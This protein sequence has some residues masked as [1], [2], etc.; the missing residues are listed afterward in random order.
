[1]PGHPV[2]QFLD[3]GFAGLGIFHQFDDLGQRGILAHAGRREFEGA[4][5]VDRPPDDVIAGLLL[6]RQAFAG[7][8]GF[9]HR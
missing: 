9:V 4:R 7:Q 6:D 3:R 2:G 5:L 1:M 8:H